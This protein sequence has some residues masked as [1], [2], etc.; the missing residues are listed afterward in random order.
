MNRILT[1]CLTTLL[2]SAFAATASAQPFSDTSSY[3]NLYSWQLGTSGQPLN[4]NTYL[5]DRYYYN[6]PNVSP[7][8]N[9]NRVQ[10]YG[11]TDYF[12]YVQPME[13]QRQREQ[14]L[15]AGGPTRGGHFTAGAGAGGSIGIAPAPT[16]GP[17]T[18]NPGAP[19]QGRTSYSQPFNSGSE[20]MPY[21]TSAPNR[22]ASYY[23]NHYYGGWEGRN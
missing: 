23:Q 4:S 15:S 5:W 1:I 19:I 7:Y 13:Q 17:S 11:G 8:L 10:P 2:A 12:T 20:I 14:T 18:Y 9:L 16:L 21:S 22:S 3:A 6:N